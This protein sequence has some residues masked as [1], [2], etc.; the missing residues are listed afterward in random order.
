[1]PPHRLHSWNLTPSEAIHAQQELVR[2]RVL[3]WDGRRVETVAGVD[4]SVKARRAR[5]AIVVLRF[6]DLDPIEQAT[7][8]AEVTFPYVPGLLTFREGPVILTAW[9][10]LTTQPDVLLFDGQGI[11]HPRGMG[12]ATHM[13]L[14]LDCPSIGVAKT[15][16]YGI[17]EAPGPDRGDAAPLLDEKDP[18]RIIGSVLR[19]RSGANPVFV[20]PG[21]RIDVEHATSLTL[22]C[23]T[24]YRL[25]ETTRAA[26]R[27]AGEKP[28]DR[29][30]QRG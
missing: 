27:A 11:A 2:R 3:A 15:K 9:R 21:H 1:M 19:T 12:L 28:K 24:R 25:P 30:V 20:S 26:H 29:R 16:L 10:R 22:A 5:G 13:G 17:H 14:W 6:P 23:C 7:A 18:E 8:E 4:V